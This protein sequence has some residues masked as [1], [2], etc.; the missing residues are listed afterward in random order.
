VNPCK[1]KK[2]RYF[3]E[4]RECRY[5]LFN[6]KNP[7]ATEM[8][9]HCALYAAS[10]GEFT[11]EEIAKMMGVTRERIRQIEDTAKIKL[12]PYLLEIFGE[13]IKD[14]IPAKVMEFIREFTGKDPYTF[15]PER[16]SS[17]FMRIVTCGKR[18]IVTKIFKL[19]EKKDFE[20][21][22]EFIKKASSGSEKK[23]KG[24]TKKKKVPE[25]WGTQCEINF[26][27]QVAKGNK[28][29]ERKI[30]ILESYLRTMDM[31]RWGN[32]KRD[33]VEAE[34]R[35]LINELKEEKDAV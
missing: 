4:D 24:S 29:K 27:R 26:L 30:K 11:L 15:S 18:R 10:C 6:R 28:S 31:K 8:F 16:L 19:F 13:E 9:R 7:E 14:A 5:V 25:K 20:K 34:A 1:K 2:C 22:D 17:V 12:I 21:I 23:V 35:K 3:R 33:I 32:I